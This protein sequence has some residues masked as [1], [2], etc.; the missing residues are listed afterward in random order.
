M[1]F[2]QKLFTPWRIGKLELK[3]RIVMPPMATNFADPE[4][5]VNERH[6]AYYRRRAGGGVGLIIFEHTGIGKQG[7][8]FPN[9]AL[10]DSDGK[11]PSFQK[12]IQAIHEEGGRIFIQINHA[13]RQTLSSI[14]GFPIVAPSPI[15]CPVRQEMPQ[16]LSVEEIRE[17]IRAY[18][19]AARRVREAGADGVEIHMAHGYLLNQFLSPFSNQRDDKYGG[20]PERRLRMPLEV[21]QAVRK[22]VGP[23]FPVTCRF[24]ADEYVEGGLRVEDSKE[25]A[26]ELEE[27]GADAL[28]VSACIGASGYL[29][30]PSY[31]SP[32][33][34]FVPLAAAVKSVVRIPVITVGR[35]RTPALADQILR[36]NRADFISM[37]R[38]LI[39]DAELPRKA[40]QDRTAEIVPC[41][42]CNRCALSIRKGDLQCAVNPE[43]GREERLAFR[44]AKP[45]KRVWVVGGGPAGLKTA[46]IAA[47][48]G[49][50]VTLFEKKKELGGQFLLAA[51]PPYKQAL[52]DFT[53]H[54]INET[55][56][57]PVEIRLGKAFDETFLEKE[58]PEVLVVATGAN[59]SLPFI[60]G[61]SSFAPISPG[62]ALSSPEKLGR[63]V[64]IIGGG[65]IGAETADF[66][67]EKGK[68]VTLVEM[69][70]GIALDLVGHLQHFLNKRLREKN[71]QILTSTKVLRF[72]PSGVWV[73]DSRGRRRIEDFDCVVAA[74]GAKPNN[75]LHQSLRTR[76]PEIFV[77]GDASRPR[78]ILE[79]LLEGEETALHF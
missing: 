22:K 72:D 33:G 3:N 42:S 63:K 10:I 56:K 16:A 6:I 67:S 70:E 29:L 1:P 54:L 40:A 51:I 11:I 74:I 71:V 61:I 65:G 21:L 17:L 53:L 41:I 15:P 77:I 36:E 46:E 9:M 30:H 19:E 25:I 44:E 68:E 79:A 59:P 24:S 35:I 27:Q 23:D 38:A 60:E 4:G 13:G 75:E 26:R 64:L 18:A 58:R 57:L 28:H 76:V 8:A 12:L 45:P 62:E 49:H 5:N 55:R 47:R 37:G 7:K 48:R 73:E 43:A 78:E 31:Y 34:V 2:Y 14:T 32:E 69:R 20:N 50:Q 66:L 39:A 52:K